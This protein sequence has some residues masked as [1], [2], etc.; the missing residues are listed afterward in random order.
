MKHSRTEF[1]LEITAQPDS[2]LA[3]S[4]EVENIVNGYNQQFGYYEDGYLD[5]RVLQTVLNCADSVP[6]I[7]GREY[8]PE[9]ANSCGLAGVQPV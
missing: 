6:Q 2:R 9:A 3:L 7:W 5:E 4:R 8:F 1:S